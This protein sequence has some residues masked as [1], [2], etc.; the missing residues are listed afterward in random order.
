MNKKELEM[1]VKANGKRRER[2]LTEEEIIKEVADRVN[3]LLEKGLLKKNL[4]K[5]VISNR[6]ALCNSYKSLAY[7]TRYTARLTG[8]GTIK[9]IDIYESTCP[10]EPYGGYSVNAELKI[11]VVDYTPE[12]ID[13][14]I[15]AQIFRGNL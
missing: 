6:C 4:G 9:D 15:K 7:Y 1:L 3:G 11:N 2:T 10:H 12:Q 14:A 8:K 5:L 13:R